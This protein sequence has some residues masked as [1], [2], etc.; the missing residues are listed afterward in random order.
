MIERF[1]NDQ[2][3]DIAGEEST[4]GSDRLMCGQLFNGSQ[5]IAIGG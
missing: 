5:P 2:L 4:E 3:S 1:L